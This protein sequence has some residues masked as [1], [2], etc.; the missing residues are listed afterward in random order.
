MVKNIILLFKNIKRQILSQMLMFGIGS[1]SRRY[2]QIENQQE[3]CAF[4]A[5]Q[6]GKDWPSVLPYLDT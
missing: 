3:R 4:L 2:Y 5:S 1:I 6:L